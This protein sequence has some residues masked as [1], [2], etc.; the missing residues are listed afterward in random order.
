[1]AAPRQA[2]DHVPAHAAE[3]NEPK[4]HIVLFSLPLTLRA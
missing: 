3:P 2:V 4:L 1:M